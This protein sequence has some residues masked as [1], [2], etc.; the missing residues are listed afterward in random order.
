MG[1]AFGHGLFDS[2]DPFQTFLR[3][4]GTQGVFASSELVLQSQA[5]LLVADFGLQDGRLAEF[6]IDDSGTALVLDRSEVVDIGVLQDKETSVPGLDFV[7]PFDEEPSLERMLQFPYSNL[8]IDEGLANVVYHFECCS[9]PSCLLGQWG[10]LEVK[11]L[12]KSSKRN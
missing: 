9:L 10:I 6:Q 4:F 7:S 8:E 11:N 5:V 3:V 12:D 1:G 2:Q